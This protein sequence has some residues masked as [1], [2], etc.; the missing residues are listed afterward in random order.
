MT[1]NRKTPFDPRPFI[2][3]AAWTFARTVPDKPHAYIVE[4]KYADDPDFR[5]FADLIEAEGYKAKFEGIRY[6]YFVVDEFVYWTSRS[7]WTPGQNL[8]RRPLADVEDD[9]QHEQTALPV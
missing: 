8:N 9:P 7:L 5:T 2:E 1:E 4:S 6:V 3:R